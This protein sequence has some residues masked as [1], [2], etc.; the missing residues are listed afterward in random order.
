MLVPELTDLRDLFALLEGKYSNGS[1]S[2]KNPIYRD[3][4][5]WSVVVGTFAESHWATAVLEGVGL[6]TELTLYFAYLSRDYHTTD[7]IS[8]MTG[9]S[10][11][12]PTLLLDVVPAYV[13]DIQQLRSTV[14]ASVDAVI[15]MR[16]QSREALGRARDNYITSNDVLNVRQAAAFQQLV[17]QATL[18]K[19]SDRV[20]LTLRDGSEADVIYEISKLGHVAVDATYEASTRVLKAICRTDESAWYERLR[21]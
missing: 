19:Q 5:A 12:D 9:V 20:E 14:R 6:E 2:N 21:E 11:S 16:C 1:F 15:G 4:V 13:A 17:W 3:L 7:H 10:C 18:G 8:E